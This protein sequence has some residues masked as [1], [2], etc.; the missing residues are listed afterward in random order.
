MDAISIATIAIAAI[1][2]LTWIAARAHWRAA[3]KSRLDQ[4]VEEEKAKAQRE[5]QA[6]AERI[7]ELQRLERKYAGDVDFWSSEIRRLQREC[8]LC[9]SP[10]NEKGRCVNCLKKALGH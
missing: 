1:G 2:L 7:A 4:I 6:S 10:L 9:G 3:K 8:A 5:I